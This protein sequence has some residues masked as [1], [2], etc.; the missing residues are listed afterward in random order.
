MIEID[1]LMKTDFVF[2]MVDAVSMPNNTLDYHSFF[3]RIL[4][5]WARAKKNNT[6]PNAVAMELRSTN[7]E[8]EDNKKSNTKYIIHLENHSHP[9]L[10]YV[11]ECSIFYRLA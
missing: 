9:M 3:Y 8:P 2:Y 11:L 5:K 4:A 6:R 7:M 1:V 10:A